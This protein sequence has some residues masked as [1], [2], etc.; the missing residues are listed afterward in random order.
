MTNAQTIMSKDVNKIDD[1]YRSLKKQYEEVILVH[2][3]RISG[4]WYGVIFVP[5]QKV[6]K[7]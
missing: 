4:K 3:D 1:L 7:A 6:A 2:E 5:E